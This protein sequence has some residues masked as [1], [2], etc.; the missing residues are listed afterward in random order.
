MVPIYFVLVFAVCGCSPDALTGAAR[1]AWQGP[2]PEESNKRY[3]LA[4]EIVV[5]K[6]LRKQRAKPDA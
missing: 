4:R 5:K 1:T 2:G 6:R 3:R